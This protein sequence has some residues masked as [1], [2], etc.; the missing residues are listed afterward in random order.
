M[1]YPSRARS[2]VRLNCETLEDRATPATAF[3]LSGSNLL[4]FDTASPAITQTTAITGVNGSETLVGIDFRPQNGLLYALGVNSAADTA[5]LYT[6]S[7]RTGVATAV[8]ASGSVSFTTD[9]TTPVDLPDPATIGYG[10]DFNPAA[11]RVRVVVGSLTFRINPNTGAGV[12]GDNTGSTSGGVT[13][14]NP[15]GPING[16]TVTVDAA[17]YTNNQ[18]NNGGITTLYTLD[19]STD[20]LFIQ[21]PPNAGTQTNGQTITL[22]GSTLDFT[23]VNGFDIVAGVD[24]PS[25]N[26]AVTTGS[27]FAVLNVGGTTGLYSINLVNGQAAFVGNVANGATAVQGFAVQSDLSGFP[28]VALNAAGDTLLR[29]NTATPGTVTSQAVATGS[30]VAGETL[31]GID[32][33]PA[34]GQLYGLG[35]DAT[36]NTATLYLVDPQTGALSVVG[37]PSQITFVDGTLST[38]D[39]PDPTTVGYGIDFNPTADRLRVTTG[40]GLNFR[41]NPN[42]GAP[43]DGDLGAAPGTWPGVNIDGAIN[44]A[45]VTGVSATAYTNSSAGSTATT[46]YTLDASTDTLYIQDAPNSGTQT[47]GLTVTLGGSTLDFTDVNGFD[48][49][50]GVSAATSN[51][52][53][54]S[55]FGY[56][57]LTVSGV[58]TVYRIDLTTGAAT[59]LGTVGT[60][61]TVLAGFT[62]ADAPAG[63]VAF[64]SATPSI[65][66]SGGTLTVNL[67]RSVGTNNGPL[68]VT[69]NVTGGTATAGLD[70]TAGPYT[71]TFADGATTASFNIPITNDVIFEGSETIILTVAS[72]SNAGAIG[73]V[74]AATVT[75]TEDDAQPAYNVTDAS[76]YALTGDGTA[77]IPFSTTNPGAAVTSIALTGITSGETLVGIDF[78]PQNGLLYGLGVNATANTA[79][80]YLIAPQTGVATAVGTGT[81]AFTTDGT[82]PVDLPDPATVGYDID[83]NPAAD[84]LRVVAGALNFRV[85]P[86]TGA[87]VDGNNGLSSVTGTNPDGAINGATANVNGTAYTNNYTNNGG[88]TTQYTLDPGTNALYI[89]NAPNAGTQTAALTITLGGSA[90]DFTAVKGFDILAGVN[91]ATSNAAPTAGTGFAIL[92]VGGADALYRIDLTT[93]AATLVGTVGTAAPAVRSLALQSDLGTVP[94]IGLSADGTQLLR[95]TTPSAVFVVPVTGVNAGETL[96]GIDFRPQTGQLYG[97]GVNAT[98]NTATLYLIDPQSGALTA[99]GT[100]AQIAFTTDGTTPVDLPDPATAGY[101][102]AF[103]PTLD[104]IRVTTSTGLNFRVNPN[105]GAPVDGDNGTTTTTGTNPDG[106]I[107]GSG[108]TGV[109][110]AAYTNSFGQPLSVGATTLY[111]LDATSNSLAIQSPA[112]SGTQ[113]A[114][115]P[116]TLN[117][118]ALDFT[119]ANGFDIPGGV[120]V[121]TSN[122][123]AAGFGYAALTVGGTTSIYAINLTTGAATK[124]SDFGTGATSLAGLALA[125]APAGTI[126]FSSTT[127]TA[128][129]GGSAAVITLVRTGGSSG[130]VTVTLARNGGTVGAT[131]DIEGVTVSTETITFGDGVT[132]VT[133][134]IPIVDDAAPESDEFLSLALSAPTDGAVLGALT[135]ATLTITDNDVAAPGPVASGP[136]VV[137][138]RPDGTTTTV[139]PFAGFNGRVTT[140]SGDVNGD[141]VADAVTGAGIN[142]H[143]KVFDGTTG[144]EIRSFLAF[145]NFPGGV[146][147]GAG[148]VNNDGFDDVIVGATVNGHVKVFSGATGA[149]LYSFFAFPGFPGEVRVAGG[150]INGDGFDDII[151]GAGINGHVKVFSGATGAEIRS[152]F[153]YPGF[154]GGVN[155]G[156]GDVDGDGRVDIVTGADASGHVKVFSGSTGAEIRSFFAYPGFSGSAR[157]AARDTNRDGFADIIVGSGPGRPATVRTF[158]GVTLQLLSEVAMSDPQNLGIFVG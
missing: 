40:T 134:T 6:V 13:G 93:G 77:L 109:S 31:V 15:D 70:F 128:T 75:I 132:A 42:T 14:T 64:A 61:S 30:L 91:A 65:G 60:G 28:A 116:V 18:P 53:V 112:N 96:V 63:T 59:A 88:V 33:R 114:L 122:A 32:F 20:S 140:A 157:V 48:I 79:T 37:T 110:A 155:V 58:T 89:Q 99:V 148:D 115:V 82:T 56:A 135:S 113:T 149:E 36:A 73:S 102:F 22:G 17:G 35:V 97:L 80:L 152:F 86:N 87:P 123:A 133:V 21:N 124:V 57:V 49:P 10:F 127:Y 92:T 121:T 4:S 101:G 117:G 67:T 25:S 150:D 156:A 43:V 54:A 126:S 23:A 108:V 139:V 129:E 83:F 137:I 144:A 105:T 84:R 147:V 7:T 153:A 94:V 47:L 85:N 154:T 52:A 136:N 24:A 46:Q 34:T 107:N 151:A 142:G 98:A 39:L 146:Y 81:F 95:A 100:P 12:D 2:V 71:A 41:V 16:G 138:T 158:D 66:E 45:G 130:T 118:S 74:N 141:G 19:A 27:A 38:V 69:V 51:T 9:G 103:N 11:D 8:G 29:F 90:L 125:S 50:A 106:A 119:D 131:G 120:R 76:G 68:T 44:G 143:V 5:T 1:R 72:V 111:T 104:R 55:G 3:A 62:L 145:A 26:A 78:R